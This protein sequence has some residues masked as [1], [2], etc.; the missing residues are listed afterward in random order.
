MFDGIEITTM[1]AVFDGD[2]VL[3]LNR[4]KNWKGWAFPGGHIE[5]G[6]SVL[7]CVKRAMYEEAGIVLKNPIFKGITNIYNTV[8]HKRHIIFN[9]TCNEYDGVANKECDEGEMKWVNISEFKLLKM[10]E[11]MEYRIPLFLQDANQELYIEWNEEE[12]YTNVL[13]CE[14]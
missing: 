2:R 13:Y 11:G 7:N 6:E 4:K 12:G 1:C 9:F 14:M 5:N 3:M 10:A 8:N